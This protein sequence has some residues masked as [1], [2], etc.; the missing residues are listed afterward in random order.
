[1]AVKKNR[2]PITKDSNIRARKWFQNTVVLHTFCVMLGKSFRT[3]YLKM[4][5]LLT[6]G[7]MK[8]NTIIS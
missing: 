8:E 1:M 5:G 6:E 4:T 3:E 7:S 2:C